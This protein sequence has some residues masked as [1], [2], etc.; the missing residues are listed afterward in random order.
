[1]LRTMRVWV[2]LLFG[3]FLASAQIVSFGVRAGIPINNLISAG[4]GRSA[5]TDRYAIGPTIEV[6]LPFRFAGS[7]DFLYEQIALGLSS[8]SLTATVHRWELPVLLKY[9]MASGPARPF[10]HVGISFNRIFGVESASECGRGIFG[11]HFYRVEGTTVAELRHR[12]THGAVIGGGVRFRWKA[13]H[14]S[15]EL[16]MTRWV[17]RNFGVGDSAL[18]SNLTELQILLGIT[19]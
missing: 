8:G 6:K 4:Q 16:R 7:C 3:S 14:V 11:E 5:S 18:R 12:G 9:D 1:M 10:V 19:F 15:P 13:I 2:A 17:D